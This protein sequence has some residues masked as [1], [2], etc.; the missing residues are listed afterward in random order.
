MIFE[1][2]N[3]PIQL[4]LVQGFV[5]VNMLVLFGNFYIKSYLNKKNA[6]K[7]E[8]RKGERREGGQ[9]SSKSE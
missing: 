5:M 6:G 2:G 4:P 8:V 3:L 9:S 1:I 7:Y